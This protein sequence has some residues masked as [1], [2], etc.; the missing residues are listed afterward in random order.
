MSAVQKHKRDKS[1]NYYILMGGVLAF[2]Y[3]GLYLGHIILDPTLLDIIIWSLMLPI[4]ILF[5]GW[6]W[7]KS[8]QWLQ[9]H[10][11]TPDWVIE[12]LDKKTSSAEALLELKDVDGFEIRCPKC[13]SENVG[14]A[15]W[16]EWWCDDCDASG[17]FEDAEDSP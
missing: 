8:F 11:G 9:I 12:E 17:K 5:L 3:V 7:Y 14:I 4:Y 1:W 2:I 16:G 13:G 6:A 10:G 15:S